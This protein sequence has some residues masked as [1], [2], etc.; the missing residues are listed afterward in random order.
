MI[1][2]PS[3]KL[4]K[5]IKVAPTRVLPPDP[6]PF[7]DWSAH[8]FTA[9]RA[10]YIILTHTASLYSTVMHGR[11][12]TCDSEFLER[13]LSCLREFMLDDGLECI[14]NEFIAPSSGTIQFSKSLNRSVTGSM[15]DF[16]YHAK[17][18]LTVRELSP[19]DTSFKLN[20][21]PMSPLGYANPREVLTSLLPATA[22]RRIAE[23]DAEDA[24]Q[25][26]VETVGLKLFKLDD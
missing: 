16:I 14:Y 9:D 23:E 25:R 24:A 19:Y 13:G 22:K 17:M 21:I 20:E 6:N 5:K 8:L 10:Q 2:R 7:A 3:Q 11:G 4:A 15:N 12:I 26:S 1:F 18:W